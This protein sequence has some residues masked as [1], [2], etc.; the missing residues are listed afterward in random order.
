M[1]DTGSQISLIS[2]SAVQRMNLKRHEQTLTINGIGK[3][4]KT[5]RSSSFGL[6]LKPTSGHCVITV[7][8]YVLPNL[9]QVLPDCE[10]SIGKC[11]HLRSMDL[12]DHEFNKH[13]KVEMILGS[14][15]VE[16]VF[17]DGKFQKD[18][19]LH[20]RNTIFGWTASG[21]TRKHQSNVVTT[22]F[23]ITNSFNLKQFWELEEVP[24]AKKNSDEE[25]A[26]EKHF[27]KT[28]YN[29]DNIFHV[30]MPFKH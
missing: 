21:V 17:R 13:R 25:I 10:F 3:A 8:A 23:C 7:K 15:V 11:F 27:K 30:G 12:A 28:T 4:S 5:Y 6:R 16:Q 20:F 1:I 24:E 29:E 19:G 18:N 9:T 14:D 22:S 26:C 2:E